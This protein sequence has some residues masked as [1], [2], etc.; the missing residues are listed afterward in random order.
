MIA[1]VGNIKS[2]TRAMCLLMQ[3]P[4]RRQISSCHAPRLQGQVILGH[5]PCAR[6]N[7]PSALQVTSIIS[8]S[9]NG[10]L[11]AASSHSCTAVSRAPAAV[12]CSPAIIS[13][14]PA[15]P[16]APAPLPLARTLLPLAP[17]PH[18]LA[19]LSLPVAHSRAPSSRSRAASSFAFALRPIPVSSILL[20]YIQTS[21]ANIFIFMNFSRVCIWVPRKP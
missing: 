1:Q 18:T 14:S 6:T 4:P 3:T 9:G 10:G 16:L 7:H 12:S 8:R 21:V 2:L 19:R 15:R 20:Y 11:P 13:C 5:R 17:A